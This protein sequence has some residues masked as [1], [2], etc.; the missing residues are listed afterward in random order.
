MA[1]A[2]TRRVYIALVQLLQGLHVYAATLPHFQPVPLEWHRIHVLLT[3]GRTRASPSL[4]DDARQ[5][6]AV[7]AVRGEA[8]GAIGPVWWQALQDCGTAPSQPRRRSTSTP[9]VVY[10]ARDRVARDLAERFVGLARAS[11]PAAIATLDVLLPDRPRRVYERA[12]G[13]TGESLARAWGL[14]TDAGYIM[15]LDRRPLDPCRD[16][17]VVMDLVPWLDPE[18]IVPLVETRLRAI[19]RRGRSGISAEWDG[20][21]LVAG[22]SGPG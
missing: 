8:R 11:G 2:Y 12:T 19:V 17:H 5:V 7:E 14:G 16:A 22:A 1:V 10:D 15:S 13:L 6:L 9:R 4:S 21:L 18:T 3:P 20:G